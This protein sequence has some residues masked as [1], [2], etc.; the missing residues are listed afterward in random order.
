MGS[1]NNDIRCP[2]PW[3]DSAT[4]TTMTTTTTAITTA[5]LTTNIVCLRSG[6]RRIRIFLEQ[7]ADPNALMTRDELRGFNRTSVGP[8]S[9]LEW[10]CI[11][12]NATAVSLLIRFGV[13]IDE[14][15]VAYRYGTL[16]NVDFIWHTVECILLLC[17]RAVA[18]LTIHNVARALG[19]APR[20][21]ACTRPHAVVEIAK[22]LFPIRKMRLADLTITPLELE[23]C[24]YIGLTQSPPAPTTPHLGVS[25]WA[26]CRLQCIWGTFLRTTDQ[27]SLWPYAQQCCRSRRDEM[28]A[29]FTDS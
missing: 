3:H 16:S 12:M 27:V 2:S 6:E 25:E 15:L 26:R 23:T 10:C 5:E 8:P 9:L 18:L 29:Y 20:H 21:K 7:G 4:T 17:E 28:A 19:N 13:R 14:S 22:R 11:N 1:G 24:V